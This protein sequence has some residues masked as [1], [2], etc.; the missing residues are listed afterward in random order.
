MFA[1]AVILARSDLVPRPQTSATQ[2]NLGVRHTNRH[3]VNPQAGELLDTFEACLRAIDVLERERLI[4]PSLVVLFST[5]DSAA[6]LGLDGEADVTRTDFVRWVERYI[7]LGTDLRCSA[8]VLSAARCAML[9]S[10]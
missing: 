9:Q 1:P 7:L 6:W 2:L 4:Q 10:L 3:L 8:L 5:M